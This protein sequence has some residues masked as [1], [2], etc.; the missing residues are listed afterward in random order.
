MRL[1]GRP[2]DQQIV[3]GTDDLLGNRSD[4]R[5]TLSRTVDNLGK[6]LPDAAVVINPREAKIF[7]RGL[8]QIL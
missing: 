5:R 3:A 6:T 1:G 7:I 4:L 8:A 2:G